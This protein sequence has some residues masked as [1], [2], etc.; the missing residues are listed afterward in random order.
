MST[1]SQLPVQKIKFFK[2]VSSNDTPIKKISNYVAQNQILLPQVQPLMHITV[3]ITGCLS[4][5][6]W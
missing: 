4:V 3:S 1:T 6:H 2:A 5:K